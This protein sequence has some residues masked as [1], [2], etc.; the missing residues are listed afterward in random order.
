MARAGKGADS[1][2]PQAQRQTLVRTKKKRNSVSCAESTKGGG[3]RRQNQRPVLL[4][5]TGWH[6]AAGDVAMQC[7]ICETVPEFAEISVH[8]IKCMFQKWFM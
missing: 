5:V 7:S 1:M 6:Y 3:W 2:G 8:R 4:A